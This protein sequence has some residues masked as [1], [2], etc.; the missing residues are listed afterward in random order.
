MEPGGVE[1]GGTFVCPVRFLYPIG[2]VM[3]RGRAV[4]SAMVLQRRFV[5]DG[6]GVTSGVASQAQDAFPEVGG[7]EPLQGH[8]EVVQGPKL[9]G[10][11]Q[12]RFNRCWQAVVR[13]L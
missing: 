7:L 3:G 1:V 2:C 6:Q 9:D 11:G 12:D 8:V 10:F 13:I 4:G 5:A